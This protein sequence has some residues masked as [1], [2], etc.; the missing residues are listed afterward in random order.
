MILRLV[1]TSGDNPKIKYAD[2]WG[3]YRAAQVANPLPSSVKITTMRDLFA[4]L[5][6]YGINT[7]VVGRDK[8]TGEEFVELYD[9][10]RE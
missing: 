6:E 9:G 4:L 1:S 7:V 5:N 2:D 3:A 8:D 10:Y